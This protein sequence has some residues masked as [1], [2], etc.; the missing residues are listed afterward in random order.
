MQIQDGYFVTEI[1]DD[2]VGFDFEATM[3]TYDQ[4]TSYGLLGLQERADLVNGRTTIVSA[5]GKGTQVTLV[6]PLSR[7]VD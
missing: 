4:R 6:V 2:G 1:R 5:P 3:D 7:D